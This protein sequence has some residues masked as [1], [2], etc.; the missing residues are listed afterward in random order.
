MK[1]KIQIRGRGA[2]EVFDGAIVGFSSR[3][4]TILVPEAFMTW[5]NDHF[6]PGMKRQPT[7]LIVEVNNPTDER[8]TSFIKSHDYE[9]DEDKLD[10]SKTS[11]VLRLIVSIVMAVGLLISLLSVYILMLS[12]FLL[13][14]KNSAK[15]ENLLLIGYSPAKVSFPYQMLTICLNLFVFVLSLVLMLLV[16]A[17]YLDML[18]G[19]FPD[20]QAPSVLPSVVAG[21]VLLLVVSAFNVIVVRSK[22]MRIWRGQK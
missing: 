2:D 5:A 1:M 12:I 11:F 7:R 14:Q 21:L 19:F 10:A 16:R 15:L 18:E 20:L 17:L 4:N 9:T 6:V 8:I 13:V 3:L 22:V